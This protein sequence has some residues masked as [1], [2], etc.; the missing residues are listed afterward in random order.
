MPGFDLGGA[1]NSAAEW[2]CGAP[3]VR[4][5]VGNPVAVALLLAALVAVVMMA[6]Y[7]AEVRAA[8]WR[9]AGR[10][11]FYLLVS[12]VS[13]MFV[14]HYSVMRLAR[15]EASGTEIREV[16]TGIEVSR[17]VGGA[18]PGLGFVPV[19]PAGGGEAASTTGT[20]A[21]PLRPDNVAGGADGAPAGDLRLETLTAFGS[22][23]DG[24]D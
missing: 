24:A 11:L 20:A 15:A 19:R 14:H 21:P 23:R 5:L 9:K 17:K 16:F 2:V 12:T 7:R 6:Q 13:L 8:G 4:K 3:V 18:G 10:A 1:V 22:S